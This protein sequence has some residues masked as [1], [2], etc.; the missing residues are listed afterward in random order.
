MDREN[1]KEHGNCN[2]R[3]YLG[4]HRIL[5]GFNR[6]NGKENGNYDITIGYWGPLK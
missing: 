1:G 4:V 3:F 2:N 6:D 5:D